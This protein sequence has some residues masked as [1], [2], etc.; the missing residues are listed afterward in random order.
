MTEQAILLARPLFSVIIPT[1]NNAD[2]VARSIASV[3]D[4]KN[5]NFELLVIND[6]ST[7]RTRSA[8]EA[9]ADPRIRLINTPNQGVS[10]AKNL[11]V[12]EAT[13]EWITFL[14]AD[15]T[16]DPE[17]LQILAS[18]IKARPSYLAYATTYRKVDEAGRELPSSPKLPKWLKNETKAIKNIHLYLF[19]NKYLINTNSLAVSS[20]YRDRADWFHTGLTAGE[21]ILFLLNLSKASAICFNGQACSNYYQSKSP[22][23]SSRVLLSEDPHALPKWLLEAASDSHSISDRFIFYVWFFRTMKGLRSIIFNADK[24]LPD[25][26]AES[27]ELLSKA[28]SWPLLKRVLRPT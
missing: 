18:L 22:Q 17:Y 3:L 23:K 12:R 4:Q 11:G 2:T 27:D 26:R 19:F 16:W 25:H 5:Q 6:G 24:V 13:G 28:L 9:I 21:D 20:R 10:K 8:I 15:D 7:D 1:Y 14:D